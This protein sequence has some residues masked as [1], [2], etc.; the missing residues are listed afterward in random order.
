MGT[1]YDLYCLDCEKEA[2]LSAGHSPI[3]EYELLPLLSLANVLTP[4][5]ATA[6]TTCGSLSEGEYGVRVPVEWLAEHSKHR[7][8]M[9]SEYGEVNG[10]CNKQ[11]VCQHC[12]CKSGYC[13]LNIEHDGA[14]STK[15]RRERQR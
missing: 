9:R 12:G 2:H 6:I 7:L 8:R 1:S 15:R 4:E 5:I 10:Q 13:D 11:V 3:R 14:C